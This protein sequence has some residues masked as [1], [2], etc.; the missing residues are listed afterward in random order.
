MRQTKL[1]QAKIRTLFNRIIITVLY[2]IDRCWY[3][4]SSI[5]YW[6]DTKGDDFL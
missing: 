2:E 4:I 5:Y 6:Q 1:V 3:G